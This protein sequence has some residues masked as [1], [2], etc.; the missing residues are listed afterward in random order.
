MPLPYSGLR[1]LLR[2]YIQIVHRV[3]F[4]DIDNAVFIQR[5]KMTV[6]LSGRAVSRIWNVRTGTRST[7]CNVLARP[8]QT[9]LASEYIFQ[10][11]PEPRSPA[12]HGL[13]KR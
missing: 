12:F 2:E 10:T 11:P 6:S 8:A 9:A 3:N 1:R 5:A 13:Q 4:M 7:F